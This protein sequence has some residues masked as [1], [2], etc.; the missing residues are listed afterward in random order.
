MAAAHFLRHARFEQ[1]IAIAAEILGAIQADIRILHDAVGIGFAR[2]SNGDAD[3]CRHFDLLVPDIERTLERGHDRLA[4]LGR[5]LSRHDFPH[6]R[7]LVAAE[8][9]QHVARPQQILEARA[10]LD[11][12]R[13]AGA[14]PDRV[15]HVLEAIDVDIGDRNPVR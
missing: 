14:V 6:H 4:Q 2:R 13:I 11:D 8:A 3:R 5:I 10:D 15:V 12:Q 1:R 7:E 9:S